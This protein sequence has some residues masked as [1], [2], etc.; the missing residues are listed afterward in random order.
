MS[1]KVMNVNEPITNKTQL[2]KEFMYEYVKQQ[3]NKE[4][5]EW[6]VNLMRS[7]EK[8][9]ILNSSKAK[10]E[11]GKSYNYVLIREEF[12][13]RF[14]PEISS[15]KKKAAR[16]SFDDELEELLKSFDAA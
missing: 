15:E 14:F 11:K 4:D 5:A 8:E 3:K 6:F 13:K 7:N 10:S 12:A 16:K 2:T 9:V 1:K